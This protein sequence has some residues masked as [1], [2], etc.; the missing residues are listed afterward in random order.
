MGYALNA[1]AAYRAEQVAN[2]FLELYGETCRIFHAPGRIN[3]IGEHTDYN[4]GFVMPAAIN[5][6]CWVAVAPTDNR[7]IQV[8]SFNFQESRVFDLDRPRRLGEW[9]DYVQGVA[10]MLERS[11]YRLPGAKMLVWSDL[12]IGSGL[13]SSAALEIATGLALLDT[14]PSPCDRARLGLA[15]QC[16]QN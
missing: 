15:C 7:A 16:A 4:D 12:P 5:L 14:Q 8:H 1:C 9:S 3:L 11:G 10:I 2:R 6:S 13:S